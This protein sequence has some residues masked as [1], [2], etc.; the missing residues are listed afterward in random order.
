MLNGKALLA[1]KILILGTEHRHDNEHLRSRILTGF[2]H[3]AIST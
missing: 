3:V 1:E 2:V